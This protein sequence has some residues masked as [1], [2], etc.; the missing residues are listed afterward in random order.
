LIRSEMEI[1]NRGKWNTWPDPTRGSGRVA[2]LISRTLYVM[3]TYQ[4][5][6]D[7]HKC[8]YYSSISFIV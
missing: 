5:N 1:S 7:Q 3:G 6:E 2:S 4:E 8:I